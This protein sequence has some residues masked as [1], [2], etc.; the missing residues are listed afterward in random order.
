MYIFNPIFSVLLFFS[1]LLN[2]CAYYTFSVTLVQKGVEE[3]L[4]QKMLLLLGIIQ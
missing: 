2:V 4:F 3:K 1:V